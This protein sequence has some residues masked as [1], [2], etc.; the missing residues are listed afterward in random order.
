MAD[1]FPP[2]RAVFDEADRA[3]GFPLSKLCFEGTEEELRQT[4]VTQPA[5]LAVSIAALRALEI[6]RPEFP[7][8]RFVA[9]HSLGEFSALV[10]AKAI[11][12]KDALRVVRERGRL[13]SRAVPAAE[14]AMAAV[15]GLDAAMVGK[16][17]EKIA[18]KMGKVLAVANFNSAEQTVI[19][20]EKAA[21]ELAK[22][23]FTELGAARFVDLAV[24]APFHSSLMAK[25]ADGLH[26]ALQAIEIMPFDTPIITNVEAAPNKD[27]ARVRQLLVDQ[28]TRPV[29]WHESM[30]AMRALGVTNLIEL[31]PGRVLSRLAKQIDPSFEVG[32][33]EE[34]VK[35]S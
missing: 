11:A 29:R 10:A 32:S 8:P 24:S 3:L 19:S 14:G 27:C 35:A 16:V 28:L 33:L 23:A 22:R 20:G 5:I 18:A 17:V 26:R 4:E 13:M 6:A 12:F 9:G 30:R 7:K 34:L 1:K 15:L 25:A 21:V 31:G 2:A